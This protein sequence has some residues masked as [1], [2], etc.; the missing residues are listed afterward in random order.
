MIDGICGGAELVYW[1]QNY[2]VLSLLVENES[3]TAKYNLSANLCKN[4]LIMP[5]SSRIILSFYIV[6]YKMLFLRQLLLVSVML[7]T[8]KML[9]VPDCYWFL[10]LCK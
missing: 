8:V 9:H 5:Y 7:R 1:T 6:T 3:L 2:S 4:Y 10:L